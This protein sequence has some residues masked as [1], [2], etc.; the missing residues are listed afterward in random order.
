[1][2]P[3]HFKDAVGRKYT[4]PY[5]QARTFP[6]MKRLI[7]QAFLHVEGLGPHVK[8]GHYDLIDEEG[9]IIL[10]NLYDQSVKPGSEISQHMW[11]FPTP[12]PP[13]HFN[14]RPG[15]PPAPQNPPPAPPRDW[16]GGPP[17]Q[18]P[19]RAAGLA[20]PPLGPGGLPGGPPVI[21]NLVR[22]PSGPSQPARGV[23]SWMAGNKSDDSSFLT[24]D[25]D[26]E[27]EPEDLG[28]EIDFDK[29]EE[30]AKLN[31]GELL[32][33]L[34]NATDTVH[35]VFSDDEDSSDDDSDASSSLV[36]D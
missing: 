4:F 18:A 19:Q 3:I 13:S 26:I 10:P 21:V 16:P 1:V 27:D 15:P 28:L 30:N 2:E 29:E 5:E 23:L 31:L 22:P 6:L 7:D 25:S 12:P 34:T 33:K 9:K 11:P 32:G 8:E 17:P 14:K 24:S 36:S 20:V 35:D